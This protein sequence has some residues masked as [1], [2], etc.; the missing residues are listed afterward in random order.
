VLASK[1]ERERASGERRAHVKTIY[2][3][4]RKKIFSMIIE[5]E[6]RINCDDIFLLS[7]V[8]FF[9]AAGEKEE[10]KQWQEC[11]KNKIHCQSALKIF[12]RFIDYYLCVIVG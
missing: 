9:P 10:T 7:F 11:D 1:R 4:K 2:I 3:S 12:A 5:K 6:I 8:L